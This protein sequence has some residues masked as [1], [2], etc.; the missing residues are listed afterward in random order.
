MFE[1]QLRDEKRRTARVACASAA[2][3]ELAEHELGRDA[4][5]D[6]S[7]GQDRS[8]KDRVPLRREMPRRRAKNQSTYALGVPAPTEFRDGPAHR[9][10]DGDE[11]ADAERVRHGDDIVCTIL[12]S[13]TTRRDPSAMA[14]V[15]DRHDMVALG[16]VGKRGKP[17]QRPRRGKAMK[18]HQRG[19][20]LGPLVLDHTD[21]APTFQVQKE[22]FTLGAWPRSRRGL[23]F[24][25]F[26]CHCLRACGQC[27]PSASGVAT[28]AQSLREQ[29]W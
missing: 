20:S 7:A 14:A 12:Q 19:G 26:W 10:S 9:I 15:I 16:E 28:A 17:I 1:A 22:L 23:T 11:L 5:T 27:A 13:K 24:L 3:S 18:Q 25:P 29:A 6:D 21:A 2:G 4:S 8:R